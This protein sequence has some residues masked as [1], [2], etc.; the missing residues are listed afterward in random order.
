MPEDGGPTQVGRSGPGADAVRKT[1]M[2]SSDWGP[3]TPQANVQR[4]GLTGYHLEV[5]C[6][7]PLLMRPCELFK[8]HWLT[9]TRCFMLNG[10]DQNFTRSYPLKVSRPMDG[11][12]F[13]CKPRSVG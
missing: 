3:P 1:K 12:G 13:F 10:D 2:E 6:R 9:S 5:G 11:H 8:I 4:V 7:K